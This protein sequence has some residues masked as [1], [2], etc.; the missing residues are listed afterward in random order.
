MIHLTGE[1]T[2]IILLSTSSKLAHAQYADHLNYRRHTECF[3][4]WAS[5]CPAET[6]SFGEKARSC[7]SM[8]ATRSTPSPSPRAQLTRP[9]TWGPQP[10]Q[11]EREIHFRNRADQHATSF[12]LDATYVDQNFGFQSV[13]KG[14]NPS[15]ADLMP[16]SLPPKSPSPRLAWL[17]LS[18]T[19]KTRA[20]QFACAHACD[21]LG[22]SSEVHGPTTIRSPNRLTCV[23][24]D[25]IARPIGARNG[26]HTVGHPPYCRAR[27]T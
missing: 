19:P 6:S 25:C 8:T 27:C 21:G 23:R 4:G 24:L 18:S 11:S 16:P 2:S 14:P 26:I 12:S 1:R 17:L 15:P 7:T 10:T 3:H 20:S 9:E 13:I 22:Q 5:L